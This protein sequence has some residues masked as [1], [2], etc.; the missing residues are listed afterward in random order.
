MPQTVQAL[1]VVVLG[2]LP[3]ALL[4]WAFERQVGRWGIGA[5]DRILRFVGWSAIFH[6][7]VAPATVG[8]WRS[9]WPRLVDGRSLPWWLWAVA[10]AYVA[11][12]IVCGTLVGRG[13]RSGRDMARF[14]AGPDPAP[15]AWDHL[16][17]IQADGWVRA[18]LK[19]GPWLGGAFANANGRRS[20]AAGYPEKSDLYLAAAVDVDPETGEFLLDD[21]GGV[22]LRPGGLL[23]RWEEVEYLEFIDA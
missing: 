3:G 5:T 15:R 13:T 16:F 2:L 11:V 1:T 22:V 8:L 19:S 6:V 7:L 21:D 12:P 10:V 20:Y 9:Q 14:F 4:V 18:K 23:V 17:G